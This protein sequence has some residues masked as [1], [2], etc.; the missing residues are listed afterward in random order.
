M[1]KLGFALALLA[2]TAG[3]AWAQQELPP[4][5]GPLNIKPVQPRPDKD[6]VYSL[7]PGIEPPRLL[8]A[9]PAVYPAD[10][11]VLDRPIMCIFSTVIGADGTPANIQL[12]RGCNQEAF[13]APAAD[14]IK[15][16][17]FQPGTLNGKPVPVLVHVRIGFRYADTPAIPQ[18]ALPYREGFRS[19]TPRARPYDQP[20]MATYAPVAP[21]SDEA[22]RHKIQGIVIVSALVTVDGLPTDVRIEK[23]LGYGLDEK[24]VESVSQYRFKPA[25]KDGVPVT[26][27][28]TVEVNFRLY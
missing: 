7:G 8:R 3:T 11:P 9:E 2:M 21:F 28:I 24:A 25:I 6:G 12:A 4:S 16:S 22:R 17:Q 13:V 26:A 18:L 23:S 20:P 15:R 27:R 14:A 1:R 19:R 5:D 10:A